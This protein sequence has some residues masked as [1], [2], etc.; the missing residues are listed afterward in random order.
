MA[1]GKTAVGRRRL[2]LVRLRPET[3]SGVAILTMTQQLSTMLGLGREQARRLLV[4]LGR[5]KTG[6]A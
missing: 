1:E 4:R 2:R 6:A 5:P 3:T